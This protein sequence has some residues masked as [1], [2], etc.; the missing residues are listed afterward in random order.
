M[1]RHLRSCLSKNADQLAGGSADDASQDLFHLYVQPLWQQP[2]HWLHLATPPATTFADLDQFLRDIWLECCGHLSSF[3]VQGM[4][5]DAH[6]YEA[7]DTDMDHPLGEWIDEGAEF[8]DQYDFGSTTP[9]TLRVTT[10]FETGARG[11]RSVAASF[12]KTS[13][14]TQR[15]LR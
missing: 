11:D 15:T 14:R 9:L 1:T 12:R 5:F 10:T 2:L 8:D 4:N 6:P 7:S 3:P 13:F